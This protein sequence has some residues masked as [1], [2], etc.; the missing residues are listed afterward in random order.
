MKQINEV[1]ITI[2]EPKI[3]K[4]ALNKDEHK[5]RVNHENL[6]YSMSFEEK[7]QII[8]LLNEINLS[9][10]INLK[11]RLKDKAKVQKKNETEINE[12][13]NILNKP[14]IYNM[15]KKRFISNKMDK[16]HI[17]MIGRVFHDSVV[18]Y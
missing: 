9:I 2:R 15:P 16:K 14:L 18:K 8:D 10:Q 17:S 1:I 13:L 6:D 11:K 4:F 3:I 5:N 12:I 7:N